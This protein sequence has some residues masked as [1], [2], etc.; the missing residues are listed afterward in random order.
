MKIARHER[1]TLGPVFDIVTPNGRRP[2]KHG[3]E[4]LALV[5]AQSLVLDERCEWAEVRDDDV[6]IARV[7]RED[8][9]VVTVTRT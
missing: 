9:T 1:Q 4:I 3:S 6:A 7:S 5:E 2:A 8:G